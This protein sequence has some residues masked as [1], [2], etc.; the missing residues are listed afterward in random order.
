MVPYTVIFILDTIMVS[1]KLRLRTL[2]GQQDS[3]TSSLTKLGPVPVSKTHEMART[4]EER[5][6]IET[7]NL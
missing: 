1:S 3:K 4:C 6:P 2:A 7:E 5:S